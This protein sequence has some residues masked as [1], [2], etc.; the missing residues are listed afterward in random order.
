MMAAY[1]ERFG[2]D[3]GAALEIRTREGSRTKPLFRFAP[4]LADSEFLGEGGLGS[5][6]KG[7][8][9][10]SARKSYI[11]WLVRNRV[12]PD[13]S[14]IS[15]Y[16]ADAKLT[17]DVA[18]GQS[19]SLYALGG[20]T[21]VKT[22]QPTSTD[23]TGGAG[24]FYFSR[25]GWRATINDRLVLNTRTA[26]IRQPLVEHYAGAYDSHQDYREWT[27]GSDL[28]WNWTTQHVLEAGWM[29]RRMEYPE[30]FGALQ[31][32]GTVTLAYVNPITL[33][34]TGYLE[35]SSALFG[36]K[37]HLF[38]GIRYDQSEH[39]PDSPVSPQVSAALQMARATTLQFG[40][41]H[42]VQNDFPPNVA[43]TGSCFGDSQSWRASNHYTASI[44]QRTGDNLRVR[45]EAFARETTDT[46]HFRASQVVCSFFPAQPEL[47]EPLGHERSRGLQLMLQRRSANRLSGWI[48][49]ALIYARENSLY[50]NPVTLSSSSF[51]PYYSTFEDQRHSLNTFVTYRFK[52]T[53]NLSGKLL[54]GSGFPISSGYQVVANGSVQLTP[55]QRQSP[56]LRVDVR[57]DKS[58]SWTRWKMTLYGEV[59]NLT[60]HSNRIV[61]SFAFLPNGVL[62]TTTAQALPITPTAGLA[63]EF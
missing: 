29:L 35:H 22:T 42:Y 37:L 17:Y 52:P 63:F 8:W 39:Y 12:G 51:T 26:Y 40:Y 25:L 57:S 59:L 31:P 44:E 41:G 13:F 3:V 27:A 55:V 24:D 61:T 15:F 14:D 47:T 23:F 2:D 1:P 46:I 56:Y 58:W 6:G 48:G 53:L 19:L 50:Y 54:F 49:Y 5:S 62:Q 28:V 9:L 16:D 20:H 33:R 10:A 11:G 43:P 7:S 30:F 60:N 21:N 18:P 36:N 32:N 34:G 38:G 4:G 45:L